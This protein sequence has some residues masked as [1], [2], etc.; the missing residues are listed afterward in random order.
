MGIGLLVAA[1]LAA[2]AAV[3]VARFLPAERKGTESEPLGI[4]PRLLPLGNS[5]RAA[6]STGTR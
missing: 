4:E 2:A 5:D 3:A 1:M 6:S